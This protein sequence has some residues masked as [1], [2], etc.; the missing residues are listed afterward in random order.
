MDSCVFCKI[1]VGEIPCHKVYEDKHGLAFLDVKPH[2]RG[3]VVIIPKKHAVGIFD[4]ADGDAR[5]LISSVVNTMKRI[6][7]ALQPDGFNVG[8]NQGT[9]AGQVVPHLHLHIFPRYNGDGG[10]SMHSI[11]RNPGEMS[12]ESVARL[13]RQ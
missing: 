10:G 1:A 6:Q 4:L 2:A 12:V 7:Q 9:A 3:H 13:F 8:W 5:N 11:V